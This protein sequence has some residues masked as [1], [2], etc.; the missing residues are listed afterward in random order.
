[1]AKDEKKITK[2]VNRGTQDELEVVMMIV[3]ENLALRMTVMERIKQVKNRIAQRNRSGASDGPK[4][5]K[6]PE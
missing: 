6:K 5:S 2:D 3:S 1:M 4:L